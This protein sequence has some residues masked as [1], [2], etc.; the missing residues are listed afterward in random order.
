MPRLFVLEQ[1]PG[2]N[3]FAAGYSPADAAITATAG[4]LDRLN[5]DELQGVIGH[6]FSH[7][8]NGDMR[9]N[10]RLIGL[11]NGILLL[12]LVGLRFLAFGGG[13]S[14]SSSK[15][16]GGTVLIFVAIAFVVLGLRR[17][18]LRRADQGRGEPAARVAGRRVLGAVHPAD[19]RAGRRV[20]EDRRPARR[21]R[22]CNDAHGERQV[23]HMLFGEGKRGDRAAVR[24]PPAAARAHRGAGP[25]FRAGELAQL[26]QQWR[27][28]RARTGWP[29]T[30]RSGSPAPPR[31]R[32][33]PGARPAPADGHAARR[34]HPRR[35]RRGQRARRDD[36]PGRPGPRRALSAQLPAAVRTAASQGSTA[37]PLV[38][39]LLVD[40]R[41]EIRDR[42]LRIV[43]ARLGPGVAAAAPV[44][45]RS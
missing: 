33:P 42:Q 16:S 45:R 23:S 34:L 29:R 22:S 3:A 37:V 2:I 31:R 20:E 38:L 18:V 14:R 35:A 43:T 7:V 32:P 13:R 1:E 30:P 41:A 6:E 44:W 28:Q 15:D 11:L 27:Q 24:D 5:R 19:G 40:E 9:L 10:V 25:G 8:L 21:A 17:P 36:E 39:A 4:A 12:G 26:Q